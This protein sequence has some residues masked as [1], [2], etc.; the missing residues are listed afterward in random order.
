MCTLSCTDPGNIH[1]KQKQW[2]S[3]WSSFSS[4]SCA[5]QLVH[6][7]EGFRTAPLPRTASVGFLL[8]MLSPEHLHIWKVSGSVQK[9]DLLTV[10]Q[11][12]SSSAELQAG[13]HDPSTVLF[14]SCLPSLPP[15]PHWGFPANICMWSHFRF[16]SLSLP[17]S[18]QQTLQKWLKRSCYWTE[19]DHQSGCT[20]CSPQRFHLHI[21]Q[22]SDL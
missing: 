11:H 20:S 7:L 18:H 4:C 10:L 21:H 15:L 16:R 17:G 6:V 8:S 13:G 14:R 19:N 2:T 12:Q 22:N 3:A 5:S 9:V 1:R